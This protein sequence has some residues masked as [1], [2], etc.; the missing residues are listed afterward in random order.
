MRRVY[1]SGDLDKD[2]LEAEFWTDD[3]Q[4]A[5]TVHEKRGHWVV[6]FHGGT[7]DAREF[8]SGLAEAIDWQTAP[9]RSG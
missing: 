2:T 4:H 1:T 7:L 3:D 8:A 6:T 5:A 9:P